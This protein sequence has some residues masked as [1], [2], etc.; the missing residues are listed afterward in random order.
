[1]PIVFEDVSAEIAPD[2][3]SVP[4][5]QSDAA[6]GNPDDVIDRVRIELA[7]RAERIQRNC[8]D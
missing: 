6:A 4:P 3:G 8:T 7:L 1:M 2:R 5:A